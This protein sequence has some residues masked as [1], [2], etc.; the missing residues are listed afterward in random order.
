MIKV[1]IIIACYNA[2]KNIEETLNSIISQDY[3]DIELVIIDG[4]STDNTMKIINNYKDN[5]NFLVSENDSGIGD[6]FNKGFNNSTGDYI[7]FI[8][9]DDTLCAGNVISNI[10]NGIDKDK[11]MFVCGLVNRVSFDNTK[12]LW[13]SNTNFKKNNLL[14]KMALPHQGLFTNRKYFLKYG[15]FDISLKY[16]MDYDLLLRSFSQFPEVVMKNICVAN[17]RAGGV[18]QDLTLEVYKEYNQIKRI[19]K[20]SSPFNLYIINLW[21]HLK[22]YIKKYIGK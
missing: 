19:N 17:W 20:I 21:I 11:D 1:T 3:F 10:M 6:A 4:G 8:G 5:V 2:E 13:T 16:A 14:I 22:Y 15:L 12:I 7:Y 18:G 9:A